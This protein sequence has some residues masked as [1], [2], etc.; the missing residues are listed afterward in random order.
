MP[1]PALT[2]LQTK[3]TALIRPY[4]PNQIPQPI[5]PNRR[6]PIIL[7]QRITLTLILVRFARVNS[8]ISK[9]GINDLEVAHE[10]D[11]VMHIP[12]PRLVWCAEFADPAWGDVLFQEVSP[13]AVHGGSE[14]GVG[15][16][17]VHSF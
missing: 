16:F 14:G 11:P 5:I 17:G 7:N 4:Q 6:L 3:I 13:V 8:P 2:L 1:N 15:S 12:F 10:I 9:I